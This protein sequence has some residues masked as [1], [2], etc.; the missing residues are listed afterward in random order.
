MVLKKIQLIYHLLRKEIFQK[1][2][3]AFLDNNEFPTRFPVI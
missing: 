1:I 3:F 2:L